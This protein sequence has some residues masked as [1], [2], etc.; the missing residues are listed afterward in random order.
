MFVT[1]DENNIKS[2]AEQEKVSKIL[3]KDMTS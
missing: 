3:S 2:K 1:Q